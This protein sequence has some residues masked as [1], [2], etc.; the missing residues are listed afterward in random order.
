MNILPAI[1]W[2]RPTSKRSAMELLCPGSEP[3]PIEPTRP[4]S[5]K[6]PVRLLFRGRAA[7]QG[8]VHI[9][10]VTRALAAA[11]AACLIMFACV[12][13]AQTTRP[14]SPHPS[15]DQ[16][17]TGSKS[18]AKPPHTTQPLFVDVTRAAGINFHLNCGS[19]EKLYIVE[20]QCGGVAA[21]DYDND[22]WMD[23]LL[24]DG[25]THRRLQSRQV[26]S[27]ASSIATITTERS[28]MS[29]PSRA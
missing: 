16:K 18:A 19:K 10:R 21:F 22:G 24:V 27:A 8:R 2:P 14:V 1:E 12:V 20:T 6:G 7:R 4:A 17:S 13:A 15:A 9:C 26:P 23:I 3:P 11:G 25:S 5:G 29:P 28:P